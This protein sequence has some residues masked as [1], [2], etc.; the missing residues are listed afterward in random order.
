MKEGYQ[1]VIGLEI[2]IQLQTA[3]KLFATESSGFI[4]EP[5]KHI[6]PITW[7]HPGVLPQLNRQALRLA[8]RMGL[9][10]HCAIDRFSRFARKHYFYPDLPKG[11]QRT[12][13]DQPICREGY[14]DL[15]VGGE[16]QQIS[17]ER[18]HLEEDAGKSIHDQDPAFSFVDL[19][20]AGT[21]LLELVTRPEI[22]SIEAAL[23]F[24]AEVRRIVRYHGVSDGDMEKGNLRCDANISLRP[25]PEAPLG[26]RVEIKNLNSFSFLQRAIEVEISRQTALLEA[27]K[28]VMRETRAF[29]PKTGTTLSLRSKEEAQD[30]R[31]L[32]EPD[33]PPLH[34]PEAWLEEE[35]SQLLELP[36]ARF[37]RYTETIS[38]AEALTLIESLAMSQYLD[39]TTA[40]GSSLQAAA[41]WM[42]GPLSALARTGQ[43]D[44]EQP[45]FPPSELAA[46]I[47][48]VETR[49]V[50]HHDA[51]ERLL[52]ALLDPGHAP[53]A[54]LSEQLGIRMVSQQNRIQEVIQAVMQEN[55][56]EVQ[57]YRQGKKALVGFFVG[58]VMKE[59]GGGVDPKEVNQVVMAQLSAPA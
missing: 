12:Q 32:T 18:I 50:S 49:Q 29:D 57:R 44:W 6:S 55:P 40:C 10:T 35:A 11:F 13:S 9:A 59:L 19:N 31:Y 15:K 30:Y 54:L 27:G 42:L 21:P 17:I 16:W 28:P 25:S 39:N 23:A 36:M 45:A 43:W 2:H 51:K 3:R 26:T 53:A 4:E 37:R 7:A 48:L 41:N 33:L 22:H 56:D 47:E 14:L 38:E 52:P 8:I 46:L 58:K 1:L 24:L 5:N 20:R 34:L